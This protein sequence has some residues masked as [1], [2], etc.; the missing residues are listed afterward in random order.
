[1]AV[2]WAQEQVN[3][4]TGS[5]DQEFHRQ[6]TRRFIVELDDQTTPDLAILLSGFVPF[7]NSSYPGDL[8]ALAQKPS[9]SVPD[10]DAPNFRYVTVPYSTRTLDPSRQNTSPTDSPIAKPPIATWSHVVGTRLFTKTADN[11][12]VRRIVN[13]AD[14]G[15]ATFVNFLGPATSGW[16]VQNSA[17]ES[18]NDAPEAE[19]RRLS[20]VVVRNEADFVVTNSR[21]VIGTTN[22]NDWLIGDYLAP[23]GTALCVRYD[24]VRAYEK[25]IPYWQVTYGFEFADDWDVI[26][27]DYGHYSVDTSGGSGH[28]VQVAPPMGPFVNLDGNGDAQT[29][30]QPPV[31]LGFRKNK[32]YDF[33]VLKLVNL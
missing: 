16:P 11:A 26:I 2:I 28:Y 4:R 20:L 27:R 12:P 8:P 3:E 17:G 19:E 23:A 10:A 18:Y 29:P 15:S 21:N 30:E 33:S 7:V 13:G 1:M 14:A 25:Q 9:V 6:Y 22:L 24:G 32:R 5:M 31:F